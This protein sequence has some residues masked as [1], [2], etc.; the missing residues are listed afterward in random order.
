MNFDEW[1]NYIDSLPYFKR[2]LKIA[3]KTDPPLTRFLYKYK[4]I[5]ETD[6][7]IDRLRD[8]LVRSRLWLSSPIDFNDPFDMSVKI[9]ANATSEERLQRIKALMRERGLSLSE[10][11]RTRRR[12]M[13]KSVKELEKDL[14]DIYSKQV[15]Q[16][17]IFSFA[18]DARSILMWSHYAR[19]HTGVCFQ[20]E[21]ARDFKTLSRAV[22][23]EYSSEYPEV[24][25]IKDFRESL[26]NALLRKHKGWSYEK[27]KRIVHL[28]LAHTYL[29]FNPEAIIGI[30]MG[31][32]STPRGQAIIKSLLEERQRANMPPV[33]LYFAQK[34]NSKYRLVISQ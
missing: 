23:V 30:I 3:Q 24:N 28:G 2:R 26:S 8:L 7:S 17:G 19:H 20:F 14:R 33:R 4:S 22:S 1:L 34:H 12:V 15:A 6:T 27:E 31:C 16:V 32:R 21:R 13:R 29:K 5:S 18:G 11:E 25:W 9:V 10:R